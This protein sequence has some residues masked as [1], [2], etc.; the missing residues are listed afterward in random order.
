MA[1]KFKVG[2]AVRQVPQ[3]PVTGT[4]VKLAVVDDDLGYL[5]Q[6]PDGNQRWFKEDQIQ[7]VE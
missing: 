5:V 4:V 6:L 2:A 3:E 1:A 7:P